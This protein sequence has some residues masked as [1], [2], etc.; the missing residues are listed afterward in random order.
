M[1]E[2]KPLNDLSPDEAFMN[3]SVKNMEKGFIYF[4]QSQPGNNW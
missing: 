3:I 4:K 2:Q 1:A